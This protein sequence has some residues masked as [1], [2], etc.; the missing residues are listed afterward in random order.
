MTTRV[1]VTSTADVWDKHGCKLFVYAIEAQGLTG[2]DSGGISAD[3]KIVITM[4]KAKYESKVQKKTLNPRFEETFAFLDPEVGDLHVEVW[5]AKKKKFLGKATITQSLNDFPADSVVDEWFKLE[6]RPA[7]KKDRVSG[8]VHLRLYWSN[9]RETITSSIE[10]TVY[11]EHLV[12]FK[13][14]DVIVYSGNGMIDTLTQLSSGFPFSRIGVVIEAPNKWTRLPELYLLELTRNVDNFL[15]APSEVVRRNSCSVFRLVERLFQVNANSVWWLPLHSPLTEAQKFKI[16]EFTWRMHNE[17][18]LIPVEL[19]LSDPTIPRWVA[20]TFGEKNFKDPT[21]FI[22]LYSAS[23]CIELLRLAGLISPTGNQGQPHDVVNLDCFRSPVLIRPP[24]G[25]AR[26]PTLTHADSVPKTTIESGASSVA[27]P[28]TAT[29]SSSTSSS[30]NSSLGATSFA[31]AGTSV[32]VYGSQTLAGTVHPNS[33]GASIARDAPSPSAGDTMSTGGAA[34]SSGPTATFAI[35]TL[36]AGDSGISSNDRQ[37]H[38]PDF[39]TCKMIKYDKLGSGA[40][41]SVWRCG[42]EGFTCAVKIVKVDASTDQF[43]IDS[44]KLEAEILEAAV[45]PN[46]VRYLGHDFRSDEMHL[47]LEFM[48]YSLRGVIQN[49][50]PANNHPHHVRRIAHEIAKGLNYLHMLDPPIIHR[51]VKA[52]NILLTKDGEGRIDQVK[53]CDFGVSKLTGEEQA[54]TYVGT[55]A[56]MAP[57]IRAG[58]GRKIYTTAVDIYSFGV[59]LYELITLQP[60]HKGIDKSHFQKLD[61]EFAPLVQLVDIC[62][63]ENPKRRPNAKQICDGL[64]LMFST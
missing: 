17:P 3:P 50:K 52:E 15:D 55:L 40:F 51:D 30:P 64:A 21:E 63:V 19:T 28:G 62:L 14:G 35:S 58:K 18:S 8:K 56:F 27:V 60:A 6:P 23:M 25:D 59:L 29:A 39:R 7:K 2:S 45:H 10:Q 34:L 11:T 46:I 16:N 4:G 32:S 54:Q 33:V 37:M 41:G 1:K 42:L 26:P 57:E 47:F 22:D 5:C 53:I 20:L 49:M 44:L 9:K 43:D 24:P 12:H 38:V 36:R 48:P 31:G 61:P 13:P